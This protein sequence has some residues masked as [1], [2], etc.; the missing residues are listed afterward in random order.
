MAFRRWRQRETMKRHVL[1]GE[2]EG[3]YI[4]SRPRGSGVGSKLADF[5]NTASVG[6]RQ[7]VLVRGSSEGW[8]R[9]SS[10]HCRSWKQ[11]KR[12]CRCSARAPHFSHRIDLIAWTSTENQPRQGGALS[13]K[14]DAPRVGRAL[15]SGHGRPMS[16][17][18]APRWPASMTTGPEQ[19]I[20]G[21]ALPHGPGQTPAG[22]R[23]AGEVLAVTGGGQGIGLAIAQVALREGARVGLI[24]VDAQRGLEAVRAITSA[25]P[26][27][28]V[29]FASADVTDALAV[30]HALAAITRAL[31]TPTVLVNNAGRNAYADPVTMTE[32]EWDAVFAVDLKGAWIC[33]RAVLP[34][35]VAA[36]RGSIIN[37]ASFHSRL[38]TAGMFPYA[39][40]KAGLVGLTRSLALEMAKYQ[41]RVNA[42]SPGYT[43]TPLLE[44]YFQRSTS[45]DLQRRVNDAHP[46]GR[47]GEASEVAEVICFLAS[48]AASFV[49]GAEWEVDGGLGAMQ[50]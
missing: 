31:G 18:G 47:I 42:V 29:Q 1:A 26:S 30:D 28:P 13:D 46:L 44:E 48:Q 9:R 45:P 27:A 14:C 22:N 21:S 49:T 19:T 4:I 7:Y 11:H 43:R 33:A 20:R 16:E 5:C 15:R 12:C 34:A 3:N 23:L 39:A 40:A 17:A 8:C 37:V 35:M 36:T 24:D 50:V 38:T 2:L 6:P 41:I 25:S 32:A 10:L